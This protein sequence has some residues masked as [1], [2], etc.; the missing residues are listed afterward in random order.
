MNQ[1]LFIFSRSNSLIGR[2]IRS[3]GSTKYSHVSLI[4]P[5]G[6]HCVESAWNIPLAIKHFSYRKG[7]YDFYKLNFDLTEKQLNKLIIYVRSHILTQYDFLFLLTRGLNSLFKTPILNEKNKVNCD[8]FIVSA[9]RYISEIELV[10][11]DLK[12]TPE[13]LSQSPYLIKIEEV[14][15]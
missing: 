10:D 15:L 9:L 4:L 12:L 3:I 14:R 2:L 6:I 1:P 13:T 7:E 8:E 5:D 11:S